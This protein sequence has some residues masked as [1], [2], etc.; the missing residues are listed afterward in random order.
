MRRSWSEVGD[1]FDPLVRLV[2]IIVGDMAKVLVPKKTSS[3]SGDGRDQCIALNVLVERKGV[4]VCREMRKVGSKRSI[5]TILVSKYVVDCVLMTIGLEF[6]V[7]Q[8]GKLTGVHRRGIW[9]RRVKV[10][11]E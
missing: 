3:F 7:M 10:R 1:T 5:C 8:E 2:K 9:M 11:D 4:K 6:I